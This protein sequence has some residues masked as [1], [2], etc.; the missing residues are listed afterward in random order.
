VGKQFKVTRE[1]IRQ[2]EAK[3]LRKMRHPTRIR[4]LHGFFE[5]EGGT[6]KPVKLSTES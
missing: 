2:I 1:R 6:Q 3:A 5:A 4:Q